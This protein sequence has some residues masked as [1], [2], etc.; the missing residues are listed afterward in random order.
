VGKSS[1]VAVSPQ[2]VSVIPVFAAGEEHF[3]QVAL[4]AVA[5]GPLQA[6][7][8]ISAEVLLWVFAQQVAGFAAVLVVA[9]VWVSFVH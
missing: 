7:V 2:A 9:Q 1:V 3:L 8:C 6:W 5:K 4:S